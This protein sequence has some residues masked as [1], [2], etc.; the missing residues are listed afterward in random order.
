MKGLH[1]LLLAGKEPLLYTMVQLLS[2]QLQGAVAYLARDPATRAFRVDAVHLGLALHAAKLLDAGGNA[3][4]HRDCCSSTPTRI[5]P[6]IS[7]DSNLGRQAHSIV[8]VDS[9]MRSV[10]LHTGV[11]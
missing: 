11:S 5:Y 1:T 7:A 4:E 6:L 10:R 2:L 9:M 8:R 3:G